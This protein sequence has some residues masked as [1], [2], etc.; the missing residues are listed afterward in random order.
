MIQR[1]GT[2]SLE[3]PDELAKSRVPSASLACLDQM[4][5]LSNGTPQSTVERKSPASEE[6]WCHVLT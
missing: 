4:K 1:R 5:A 6:G 3:E 2:S